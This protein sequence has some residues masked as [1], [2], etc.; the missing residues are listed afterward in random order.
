M[1]SFLHSQTVSNDN[2]IVPCNTL[3]NALKLKI[4]FEKCN[5]QLSIMFNK[6]KEI[7]L[8]TDNVLQTKKI[9]TEHANK[10]NFYKNEADRQKRLKLL[11][12]GSG[13]LG[14]VASIL[15]F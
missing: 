10:A 4:E 3:K 11:S 5:T 14:V 13:I 7:I 1:T 2:C 8:L 6:D 12:I 15:L 9:A